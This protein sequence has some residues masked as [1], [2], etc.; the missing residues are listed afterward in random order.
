MLTRTIDLDDPGVYAKLDPADMRRKL[1]D[2][3]GLLLRGWDEAAKTSLPGHYR[4]IS[5]VLVHGMG[6]SAI[7]G[8]VLA[9]LLRAKDGAPQVTTQHDYGI[10]SWVGPDTLI[11]ASSHSG[12]T[13]EVLSGIEPALT[14]GAKI[15]VLTARGSMLGR[16]AAT[17]GLPLHEMPTEGPPRT[18]LLYAIG[19]VLSLLDGLGLTTVSRDEVQAAA[20]GITALQ[21]RLDPSVAA[22]ENEAK[23][24]AHEMADRL[25]VIL[26]AQTLSAVGRSWKTQINE[27]AKRPA[28]WEELPE[29]HHNAIVGLEEA[30]DVFVLL[31]R[32]ASLP[33]RLGLRYDLTEEVMEELGAPFRRVTAS[34][35]SEIEQALGTV[36]LGDY[37]SYYLAL[38]GGVDPTPTWTLDRIKARLAEG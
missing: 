10:P 13:E 7:L 20:A 14:M 27:N 38:L 30:N 31:L 3:P 6:G 22:P 29:A 23:A 21:R 24:M 4:G 25:P 34:G 26:S 17:K 15:I 12:E 36:L 19:A 32:P 28:L 33:R 18:L 8:E 9:D 5:R 2:C 37:V 35:A 11:V 1:H 16:V